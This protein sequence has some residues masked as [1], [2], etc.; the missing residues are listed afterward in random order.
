MVYKEKGD[1]MVPKKGRETRVFKGDRGGMSQTEAQVHYYLTQCKMTHT[2]IA[3]RRGITRQAVTNIA[4]K[5]RKKGLLKGEDTSRGTTRTPL[6]TPFIKGL[7]GRKP[8]KKEDTFRKPF[9]KDN[10]LV[11]LH[12]L[13]YRVKILYHGSNF[14]P[15]GKPVFLGGCRVQVGKKSL[16]IY[17]KNSY[18]GGDVDEADFEALKAL[19]WLLKK[20]E[21][22]FKVVLVKDRYHNIDRVNA[23]YSEVNNELARDCKE[24]NRQI[25]IKASEDGKL[26][27]VIDNSFNLLEA[28]CVHPVT[29]RED[30]VKVKR[31]FDDFRVNDPPT[32]SEIM[33]LIK[34]VLEVNLETA[35]GLNSVVKL[36]AAGLPKDGGEV[37]VLGRPDYVG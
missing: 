35:A 28:E 30:F 36:L 12:S 27:F 1:F 17:D 26:W 13:Q 24:K 11:R 29:G 9:I 18:Y 19:E 2:Q 8:L 33:V 10:H 7:K 22:D 32:N 20:L 14:R 6:N 25:R 3:Q 31:F 21:H 34:K 16:I 37:E 23:H 4:I 5:L 15:V